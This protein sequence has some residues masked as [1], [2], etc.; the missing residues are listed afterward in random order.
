MNE[1]ILLDVECAEVLVVHDN[2]F[3]YFTYEHVNDCLSHYLIA[4]TTG[5]LV[6]VDKHMFV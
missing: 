1:S 3:L 4:Q 6:L 5:R 2:S